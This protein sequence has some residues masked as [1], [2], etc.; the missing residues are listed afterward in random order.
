MRYFRDTSKDLSS[1]QSTNVYSK[2][3]KFLE[4]LT[5][6]IQAIGLRH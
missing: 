4:K 5:V 2:E 1:A 6:L 3:K